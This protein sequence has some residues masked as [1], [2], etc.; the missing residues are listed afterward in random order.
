MTDENKYINWNLAFAV[1]QEGSCSTVTLAPE[2]WMGDK[3]NSNGRPH[4]LETRR[5]TRDQESGKEQKKSTK[6]C[7]CVCVT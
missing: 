3:P 2:A 5:E 1:R 4:K 6:E 7:E